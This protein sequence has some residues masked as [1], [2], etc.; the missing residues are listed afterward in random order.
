MAKLYYG[1][2]SCTI[3]GSN[4]RGVLINYRGAIEIE[5]KTSGS[6]VINTGNNKIIIFPVGK[7]TLNDLF[8][9][10]GEFRILSVVV[11]DHNAEK[12]PTTIYRVMDYS[13]LLYS[14][15]EDLTVKSEDLNATYVS[16]RRVAKTRLKQ[17]KEAR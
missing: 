15:A 6:F 1:R 2:G 10:Q 5:D 11:A 3:E 13:E 7:G 4:I 8:D 17:H 16:G 9:Y 14:K 12:V